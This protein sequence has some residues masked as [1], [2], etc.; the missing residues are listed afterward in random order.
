MLS[1][2]GTKS[3]STTAQK[4]PRKLKKLQSATKAQPPRTTRSRKVAQLGTDKLKPETPPKKVVKIEQEELCAKV[5]RQ[6]QYGH[7][8]VYKRFKDRRSTN[9]KRLATEALAQGAVARLIARYKGYEPTELIVAVIEYI[10]T[11]RPKVEPPVPEPE[12]PKKPRLTERQKVQAA[13]T[14]APPPITDPA[15]ARTTRKGRPK[16]V[17][18]TQ[19]TK[20]DDQRAV[21]E[22]LDKLLQGNPELKSSCQASAL[23][24]DDDDIQ[25]LADKLKE[26]ITQPRRIATLLRQAAKV[27][28][29]R[30]QQED[31]VTKQATIDKMPPVRRSE[32]RETVTPTPRSTKSSK[33]AESPRFASTPSTIT[34][35][36]EPRIPD[37]MMAKIKAASARLAEP[38]FRS[39]S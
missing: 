20:A 30:Y 35:P 39:A 18:P 15:S 14:P 24:W 10:R 12:K 32:P 6:L 37:D 38:T 11:E 27:L 22:A 29:A 9:L 36:A 13:N 26:V 23:F 21:E 25:A 31:E 7:V 34:P 2:Q 5:A 1:T 17:N 19:D 33:A 28:A 3:P 8:E 4:L 16:T